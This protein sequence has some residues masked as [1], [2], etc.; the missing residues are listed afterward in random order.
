MDPLVKLQT[1][2]EEL[3]EHATRLGARAAEI[4]ARGDTVQDPNV[5]ELYGLVAESVQEQVDTGL[6]FMREAIVTVGEAVADLPAGD[7]GDAEPGLEQKDADQILEVLSEH[8]AMLEE[9]LPHVPEPQAQ[10]VLRAKVEK[11][12]AVIELVNGL[13][14]EDDDGE[15]EEEDGDADE[16]DD[17]PLSKKN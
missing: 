13:V 14:L 12:K 5:K 11:T 7:G 6:D 17:E 9:S 8:L 1:L 10:A 3:D 16:A 4:K 2:S 15:D